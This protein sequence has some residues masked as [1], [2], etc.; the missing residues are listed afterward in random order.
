M[1]PKPFFLVL[2]ACVLLWGG[3]TAAPSTC[4]AH[5]NDLAACNATA[6]CAWCDTADP[7]G[8]PSGYCYSK[9]G[10]ETCCTGTS[11]DEIGPAQVLLCNAS[12]TCV[13]ST[14]QSHYGPFEVPACCTPE[15]PVGCNGV[16]YP[17]GYAC[18][19][20]MACLD[21]QLCCTD[22]FRAAQCC[23]KLGVCCADSWALTCC[24]AATACNY[25]S[26]P[27]TCS[28]Q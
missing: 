17:K 24:P 5:D 3:A 1:L 8:P 21:S 10:N 19:N 4:R 6:G 9:S 25:S 15:F 20:I 28:P 7:D 22:G 12:A 23:E 26:Y 16:C 14:V 13:L 18:C 2:G 27:A 11:D